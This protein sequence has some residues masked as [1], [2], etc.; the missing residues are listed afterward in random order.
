MIA[1]IDIEIDKKPFYN[2]EIKGDSI[3]FIATEEIKN[4]EKVEVEIRVVF[5]NIQGVCLN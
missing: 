1:E 2:F 5:E 4:N 3:K